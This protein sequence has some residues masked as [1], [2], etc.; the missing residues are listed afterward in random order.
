MGND[1]ALLIVMTVSVIT[2][3]DQVYVDGELVGGLDIIKEMR[4]GAPLAPQLGLAPK[5]TQ[6]DSWCGEFCL[7]TMS[8]LRSP[9]P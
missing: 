3:A 8:S 1:V 4:T 5:V 9:L 7:C 2:C 6:W